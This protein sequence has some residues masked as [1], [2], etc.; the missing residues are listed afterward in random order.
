MLEKNIF[1]EQKN[2]EK[3]E[4]NRYK[5]RHEKCWVFIRKMG[6]KPIIWKAPKYKFP[7]NFFI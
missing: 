6:G 3:Q 2:E 5:T 4:N 7:R 1:E